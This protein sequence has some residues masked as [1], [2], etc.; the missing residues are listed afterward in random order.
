MYSPA[1]IGIDL[2]KVSRIQRLLSQHNKHIRKI[3]TVAEIEYCQKKP[4]QIQHFAARFAAKEAMIKALGAGRSEGI[5]WTDIEIVKDGMGRPKIDL[6]GKAREMKE[7]MNIED[8]L[9]SLSHSPDY[10]IAQVILVSKK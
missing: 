9:V 10:A 5:K 6:H 8:I 7:K 2:I 1:G 3:F 4:H